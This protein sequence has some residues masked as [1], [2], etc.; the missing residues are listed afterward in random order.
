MIANIR[1]QISLEINTDICFC[2]GTGKNEKFLRKVNE[3]YQFF[4]KVI[5]LE[6]PRFI[7][8]YKSKSKQTYVDKYMEAFGDIKK[9]TKYREQ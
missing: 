3:E 9:K 6:H 7:M 2:F 5:A 8:Q 4:K 1:K